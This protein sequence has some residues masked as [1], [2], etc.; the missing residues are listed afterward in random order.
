M[1]GIKQSELNKLSRA[2]DYIKMQVTDACAEKISE[3]CEDIYMDARNRVPVQ[4]GN[5][6]DSLK[7]NV[8]S[9]KVNYGKTEIEGEVHFGEP[10]HVGGWENTEASEYMM[11]P[12]P[13]ELNW[14]GEILYEGWRKHRD[15]VVPELKENIKRKLG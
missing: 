4:T 1:A 14:E 12:G 8:P 3:I 6:Q 9:Y 7:S 2:F 15:R 13:N 5:L 10:G 11:Q